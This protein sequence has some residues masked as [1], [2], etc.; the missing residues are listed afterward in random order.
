MSI[1]QAVCSF[2]LVTKSLI[3]DVTKNEI[4]EEMMDA[5]LI[6]EVGQAYTI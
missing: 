1:L 2:F 5:R 6:E 4:I 3:K